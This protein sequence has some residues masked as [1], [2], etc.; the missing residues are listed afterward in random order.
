M[1]AE[2]N[3][4]NVKVRFSFNTEVNSKQCEILV[5]PFTPLFNYKRQLETNSK[6]DLFGKKLIF[7]YAGNEI[8]YKID[9]LQDIVIREK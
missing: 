1:L 2:D 3:K 6:M 4:Q 5:D 7:K 8:Q 9:Y